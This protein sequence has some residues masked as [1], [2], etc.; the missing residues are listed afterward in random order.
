MEH[1]SIF[2]HTAQD[3]VRSYF[4]NIFFCIIKLMIFYYDIPEKDRLCLKISL[5]V[6]FTPRLGAEGWQ[7]DSDGSGDREALLQK[8][9]VCFQCAWYRFL[10]NHDH[11]AIPRIKTSGRK[12]ASSLSSGDLDTGGGHLRELLDKQNDERYKQQGNRSAETGS[13][14]RTNE[15]ISNIIDDGAGDVLSFEEKKR[16]LL[17]ICDGLVFLHEAQP[18]IIHRDIKASNIMVTDEGHVM[19]IDYDAAKQFVPGSEKDTVLIGTQGILRRSSTVLH[20]SDQRTDIYAFPVS[21]SKE[22][23]RSLSRRCV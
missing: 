10:K 22:F 19:I 14:K 6:L 11:P 17:E 15:D 5:K 3:C 1:I 16:I 2:Y 13:H 20:Q 4:Y 18:P 23:F 9:S 12:R 8:I 21:L 7:E